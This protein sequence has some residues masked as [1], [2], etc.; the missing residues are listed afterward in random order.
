MKAN[1]KSF[2][3][4]NPSDGGYCAIPAKAGLRIFPD[5]KGRPSFK[6][7]EVCKVR[8][9]L[10]SNKPSITEITFKGAPIIRATPAQKK[11]IDPIAREKWPPGARILANFSTEADV[12]IGDVAYRLIKVGSL[13]TADTI[14]RMIVRAR[15]AKWACKRLNRGVE[16]EE[17]CK[18]AVRRNEWNAKYPLHGATGSR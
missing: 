10:D 13:G 1:C 12:G 4:R 9:P 2:F 15:L 14:A 17:D 8:D 11:V 6:T 3:E 16:C 5:G 18:C 7:C